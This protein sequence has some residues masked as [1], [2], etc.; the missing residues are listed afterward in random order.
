M[1]E[2]EINIPESWADIKL[3][4]YLDFYKAIKP[5]EGTDEY[6]RIVFERS[7][8]HFCNVSAEILY[9]LPVSTLDEMKASIYDFI[10][11]GMEQP[12]ITTFT[13]GSTE[14][15]FEPN[16]DEL[17]YG[18]YLDAVSYSKDVWTYTPLLMSVLYRPV[19][20]KRGQ[21]YKIAPYRGTDDN[22]VDL[23][24]SQLTMDI[25]WGAISFFL[26]LQKELVK[27][28]L[29]YSQKVMK[30]LTPDQISQVNQILTKNGLDITQLQHY[31]EMTSQNLIQ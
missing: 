8:L 19:V 6:Q 9:K 24:K 22:V 21:T 5:Y 14:Y 11:K 1:T 7:I 3:P 2:I 17:N 13:L 31:L 10:G 15:G 16:L 29:A 20:G 26:L 12:L 27:D 4:Q 18:P 28:T 23:F 25:V 30:N